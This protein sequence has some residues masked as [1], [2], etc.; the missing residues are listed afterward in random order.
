VVEV[1][2]N[3]R[4]SVSHPAVS[5]LVRSELTFK[6]DALTIKVMTTKAA[7][8][9]CPLQSRRRLLRLHLRSPVLPFVNLSP[10]PDNEFFADG[11]TDE[12][13]ADLSAIHALRV[14]S[15]TSTMHFKGR[16][17]ELRTIA[18]EL[19][20]RYLLEGS[21]RRAGT[22]LR[23][24]AQLIDVESDKN[25][26]VE[27]Y[28]GNVEDVFAIQEEISRKI[29]SALELRLTDAER[30]GIAERPIDNPAAYDCYL[31]ARQEVYLFSEAGLDR[32]QKLVDTGLR[33]IGENSLL[34][35][36]RGLVS[37]Y[38]LNFSIRPERRYLDEAAVY[39]ERALAQDSQNYLCIFLR[40]LVASKRG[41]IESA[42]RDLVMA[43]EARPGDSLV[44]NELIRHLLT[45]G[46]EQS[47]WAQPIFQLSLR[48]DPLA[49][50]NW[51]QA[52]WRHFGAGA[53]SGNGRRCAVGL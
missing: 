42:V 5:H 51:A 1:L 28:S 17:K 34:L 47:E 19:N 16:N 6:P 7:C 45:A 11:L 48:I 25:L 53:T 3:H 46:Q 41:E 33:L 35:A 20:V 13:I 31:R 22:S 23:I 38:Y 12:V 10:D 15:R 36:T 44:L 49:P 40:G 8:S 2:S 52:A 14:I 27:K 4:Q 26:W 29:V 21:V 9:A 32:A 37:W 43:H 39:A 18:Q 30:Q 50:L 24:T